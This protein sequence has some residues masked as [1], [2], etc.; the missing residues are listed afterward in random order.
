MIE[1]AIYLRCTTTYH[2]ARRMMCKAIRIPEAGRCSAACPLFGTLTTIKRTF[3]IHR[4]ALI[5]ACSCGFSFWA[6]TEKVWIRPTAGLWQV[7]TNWSGGTPP[8]ITSFIQITNG[9]T[10]VVTIDAGTPALSARESQPPMHD[11]PPQ[12]GHCPSNA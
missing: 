6:H 3:R 2:S 8:D 4:L 12:N 7:G 5:F 10:K 9:S 11:C 1:C